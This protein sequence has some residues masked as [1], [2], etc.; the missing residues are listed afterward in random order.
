MNL[1]IVTSSPHTSVVSLNNPLQR[2]PMDV[3]MVQALLDTLKALDPARALIFTG[4]GDGFS[5]G[6]RADS[7][8]SSRP[9]PPMSLTEILEGILEINA[10]IDAWP[11]PTA[12]V[13]HGYALGAGLGLALH[14]DLVLA[15]EGTQLAFPEILDDLPA[16]LVVSYLGRFVPPKAAR[17]LLMTGRSVE[18]QDALAMGLISARIARGTKQHELTRLQQLFDQHPASLSYLKAQFRAFYPCT[19]A[20][21][22][23]QT[24][25][26]AVTQWLA[27]SSDSC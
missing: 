8:R 22:D 2:N 19:T 24:G 20:R 9:S 17:Y 21:D 23:M 15:E 27:R 16:A 10:R 5:V 3:P 11:S 18:P 13:L 26:H 12:A 1:L 7:Q 25:I 6:R 4:E 14:C